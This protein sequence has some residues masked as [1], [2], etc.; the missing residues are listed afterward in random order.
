MKD[1]YYTPSIEEFHVGLEY[2]SMWGL[3]GINEEWHDEVYSEKDSVSDLL[4]TLRVK[5]LDSDDIE[6]CDFIQTDPNFYILN[7]DGA[8]LLYL[9][10]ADDSRCVI[11]LINKKD[12]GDWNRLFVGTIKNKS[13]LKRTLKQI[14]YESK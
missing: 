3:K 10:M 5:Y 11:G 4:E 2:Q 6:E 8:Y 7:R 14:G 9:Q 13:E 1:K 12:S